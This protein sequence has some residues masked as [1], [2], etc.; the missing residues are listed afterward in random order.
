MLGRGVSVI[1]AKATGPTSQT[2]AFATF[3]RLLLSFEPWV[4]R[5]FS[6]GSQMTRDE[7][8]AVSLPNRD[9]MSEAAPLFKIDTSDSVAS[10]T[11]S[12]QLLLRAKYRIT[13]P[14]HETNVAFVIACGVGLLTYSKALLHV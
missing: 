12:M 11:S 10:S 7:H 14:R 13:Y 8:M 2:L 9:L 1:D 3:S 6:R 5:S 4:P